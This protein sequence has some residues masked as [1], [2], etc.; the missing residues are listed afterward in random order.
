MKRTHLLFT[1]PAMILAALMFNGSPALAG[2]NEPGTHRDRV[3]ANTTDVYHV[4]FYGRER[5][6]VIVDGSSRTDLDL[7]IYDPNGNLVDSDTDDTSYCIGSFYAPRP[8][9]YT[10]KIV[11]LGDVGNTYDLWTN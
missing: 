7:Y 5:G 3:L 4:F 11:N 9:V 2:S 6:E 8:G 1:I 10:I